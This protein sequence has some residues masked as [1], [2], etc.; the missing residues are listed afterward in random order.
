MLKYSPSASYDTHY[1][2]ADILHPIP[3]LHYFRN[4]VAF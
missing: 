1:F 3:Y 2:N 4:L